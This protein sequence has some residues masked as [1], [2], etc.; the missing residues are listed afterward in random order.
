ML[1]DELRQFY[2]TR[3]LAFDR[4]FQQVSAKINVISNLR[5][6]VAILV[7][8]AVWV[9]FKYNYY[10]LNVIP[11]LFVLFAVLMQRHA[12]RFAEKTRLQNLIIIQDRELQAMEGNVSS[13]EAGASFIDTH[14]P[15]THDL[16]IFG[17]GS[18]F[19]YLNR[20]VTHDG[21]KMLAHRLEHP[22]PD[23]GS[24]IENQDGV[25]ELAA[26]PEFCHEVQATG[27][28]IEDLSGDRRQ[29]SDW[30]QQKPFLWG[31][32][33]M[34]FVRW[35]L[36]LV[37]IA[38]LV[39]SF[40]VD[41]ISPVFWFCALTQW[42]ILAIHLKKVNA[43]HQYVSNKKTVLAKY[44]ELLRLFH[45]T[46]FHSEKLVALRNKASDGHLR[47]LQL[48]KLVGAL[49]ARLNWMTN[50]V[51]NSFLLYDLQCIYN[52]E[53]WKQENAS[54]LLQWLDTINELE[55][56]VS[57]GTLTFNNAPFTFPTLNTN[58]NLN[59]KQMGHP[60]LL[61]ME[62]VGND[63]I[64][65]PASSVAIITGANMAGKSTFLRTLGTNVVLA[66]SGAPVCAK[67]FDCP[68]ISLRTGM[69]TADSLHDHQSYFYAELNRLKRIVDELKEGRNL[70]ILLDEILKGTNSTDKQTGSIALVK[71][72]VDYP[73][74]VL[75]A[76][77]DLALGD[78]EYEYPH[79]V[80]NFCF[81]PKIDNDQLSFDY[82]LNR[83]VAQ[84]MNATFLMK[85]MGIIP[86]S[87]QE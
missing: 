32:Q 6:L 50:L 44:A 34:A 22:L 74:L 30:L 2:T 87:T 14:H 57:L 26:M 51:V 8:V 76:T 17:E 25:K 78:L 73:S 85:K 84:K 83:G 70:L 65:D 27:M 13:F 63:I 23:V 36:P 18:L 55:V 67:S 3:R 21:K 15:Y 48:S 40:L 61:S 39:L 12:R 24:I 53:K 28:Q 72:L 29:L 38:L 9:G 1:H 43:F 80:R 68:L 42:A 82:K 60:L 11:V 37:T 71:Q 19:Q 64:M 31:R 59:A 77:H 41:G 16:D 75:I 62:R 58:R 7:I 10:F 54:S 35:M 81:E 45:S 69:R 86:S 79:R 47:V 46:R 52:L 49:D 33:W 5:L 56:L 20:C 66:L 4:S